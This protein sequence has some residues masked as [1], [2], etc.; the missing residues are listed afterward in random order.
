MYLNDLK[1]YYFSP[2][3]PVGNR[4][5]NHELINSQK[6]KAESFCMV[7][8]N[9]VKKEI[10]YDE[11]KKASMLQVQEYGSVDWYV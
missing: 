11:S 2:T 8:Q 6:E 7:W 5:N 3:T 9:V 1:N 10:E 4:E